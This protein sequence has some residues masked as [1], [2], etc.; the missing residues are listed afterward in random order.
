MQERPVFPDDFNLANY[1]L[2][3]RLQEGKAEKV[4]LRYG[5]REYRYADV[6][7]RT[8]ALASYFVLSG[9]RPEER[10]YTVLPDAPPF[11]WSLFAT[12]M[13]GGVVAMGN[14]HAPTKDLQYVIE[15]SR[16]SVLITTDVAAQSLCEYLS[17]EGGRHL[18]TLLIVPDAPT[19]E[20]PE[21]PVAIPD[22]G[23]APFEVLPLSEALAIGRKGEATIPQTKRDDLCMWLFTSGSTGRPKAAMHTH[24]DFAFNTEVYAKKTVGYQ[25]DDITVSVPRLFFGYATGTNLFFPFAV[26][27]TVG[28]FSERPTPENLAKAIGM[29]KP[30]VITNVPTMM[31]KLLDYDDKMKAEGGERLDM[32]AVRFQ[33]SGGEALPP[34]LYERFTTRFG[35]EV[36]D[37][38][39]SAEMFHIYSTNRPG[40]VKGG[41]L[42]KAVE[43]YELQVLPKDAMYPGAEPVPPGEIGVL[44]VRGD[45]VAMGYFQDRDRSWKTFHGHWCR[46][47]DLFKKD[48]EGYLWFAGRDDD[49]FK[50][51]GVW[52]S[53]LEVETCLMNHPAVSRAAVI[54]IEDGGLQKPKAFVVL[55][56][57]TDAKPGEE[58]TLE[59]QEHC[60]TVLSKHKYPRIVEFLSEMPKNDRGKINKK[61]LAARG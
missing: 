31:G 40:D 6:A 51:S 29:Y 22:F 53:P 16:A 1:C 52:V 19:G 58:L 7:E 9:M 30:T 54:K 39:G 4:A 18:R 47:G 23:D 33:L 41:S 44:W 20:D 42:G 59:L 21:G 11:A 17:G 49:L 43:G 28:L 61:A 2:F 12:L 38:I 5:D 48:A 57:D 32:S 36:F 60:K 14:P 10:V 46:T 3:D 8:R 13:S 34:A 56:P 15:Y 35:G 37:G 26:G 25:E 55:R 24:R 45:S 27:A 50:V